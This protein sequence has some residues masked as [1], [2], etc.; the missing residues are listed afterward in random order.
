[1]KPVRKYPRIS[2]DL[3]A[4]I[5]FPEENSPHLQASATQLGQGG[6]MLQTSELISTN[7]VFMLELELPKTTLRLVA[8]MLYEYS[9]KDGTYVG[10]EFQDAEDVPRALVDYVDEMLEE[11]TI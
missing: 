1:M 4:T 10:V 8:R 5:V 11:N 7:S 9:F 2:C 6:C 3:P